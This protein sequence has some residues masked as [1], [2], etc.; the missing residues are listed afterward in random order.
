MMMTALRTPVFYSLKYPG[1]YHTNSG[2]HGGRQIDPEVKN[3]KRT[4]EEVKAMGMNK[5]RRCIVL[6]FDN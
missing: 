2:C 4:E 5:C 6:D 1:I 3:D